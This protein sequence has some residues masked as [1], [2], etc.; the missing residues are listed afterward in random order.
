[1]KVNMMYIVKCKELFFKKISPSNKLS[2]EK[3]EYKDLVKIAKTDIKEVGIDS[4]MSYFQEYQYLIDLWTAHI[5]FDY[6]NISN[7]E[8]EECIKVI[9]GYLNNPLAPEIAKEEGDWLK[10]RGL[11]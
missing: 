1:M 4:F 10:E 3:E 11:I 2:F 8:K 5:L 9:K 7:D 6:E